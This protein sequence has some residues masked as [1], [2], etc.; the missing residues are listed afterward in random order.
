MSSQQIM[1]MIGAFSV[2]VCLT[3][4]AY[5]VPVLNGLGIAN[6]PQ[7]FLTVDTFGREQAADFADIGEYIFNGN[8]QELVAKANQVLTLNPRSGLAF[9]ALGVGYLI[10]RDLTAAI[11]AFE[12]AARMEPKQGGVFTK[13]GLAY[14]ETDRLS[15]AE[16]TFKLAL[17]INGNDAFAH[18]NLGLLYDYQGQPDQAMGE[19]I[20]GLR[21]SYSGFV[22]ESLVLARL[23][24]DRQLFLL[25]IDLLEPRVPLILAD[26]Q[27][28]SS[29]G[30]YLLRA[31]RWEDALARFDRALELDADSELNQVGR[32]VALRGVGRQAE[33]VA[34]LE[35]LTGDTDN[36]R[37]VTTELALS[38]ISAGRDED[39]EQAAQRA[40][41]LGTNRDS[42]DELVAKQYLQDQRLEES[43]LAYQTLVE[44]GTPSYEAYVN[45]SELLLTSGDTDGA[46][47]ALQ[48][49]TQ[50]F[51]TMGY[52]FYRLGN[53][54]AALSDYDNALASLRTANEL[55]PNNRDILRFLSLANTRAGN[56][57]EALTHAQA[58]LELAPADLDTIIFVALAYERAGDAENAMR[59]YEKVLASQP[60]NPLV[61]N[62]L[63]NIELESGNVSRAAELI[64]LA[65]ET[66]AD[67]PAL[68]DTL[69]YVKYVQQDYSG[70]R[71]VLESAASMEPP[72]G[73]VQY[74]LGLVYEALDSSDL[75]LQAYERALSLA[76]NTDWAADAQMRKQALAN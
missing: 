71:D 21:D 13:L 17:E 2:C 61:L 45:L 3:T 64:E 74:H 28:Q 41:E 20:L 9:E 34:L 49:A 8:G 65:V 7:E 42:L 68:L 1:R 56:H 24:N 62:N 39:G 37:A 26:A 38:L 44:K 59:S 32:A 52:V 70:A 67:N 60:N 53:T 66:V 43:L 27:A 40:V 75:A 54:Y 31:E 11:G 14:M 36:L 50:R 10:Q 72:I 55:D 33:S 29:L 58:I 6:A 22:F 57:A 5:A 19:L 23:Y 18:R 30:A 25:S 73:V 46:I 16:A 35:S 76:P 12:N 63:A 48:S 51:P 4:A 69:G 47:A 15:E